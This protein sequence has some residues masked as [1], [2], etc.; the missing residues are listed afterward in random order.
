M[1]TPHQPDPLSPLEQRLAHLAPSAALDG[2]AILFAAGRA[3][4]RRD[5]ARWRLA[6]GLLVACLAVS[7]ALHTLPADQS[8]SAPH[9]TYVVDQ[10]PPSLTTPRITFTRHTVDPTHHASGQHS[11]QRVRQRVLATGLDA[12]SATTPDT[13]NPADFNESS[14]TLYQQR[15]RWFQ[16]DRS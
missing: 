11:Y 8:T 9:T 4:G 7:L 1:T 13:D 2:D 5:T 15:N 12:L 16:G 6:T 10:A 3:A 14:A